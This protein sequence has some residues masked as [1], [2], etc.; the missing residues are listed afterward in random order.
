MSGVRPAEEAAWMPE[1]LRCMT[2]AKSC[3]AVP[4]QVEAGKVRE[5]LYPDERK[6]PWTEGLRQS[7]ELWTA[8]EGMKPG[9]LR[10][11]SCWPD[12]EASLRQPV[13]ALTDCLSL[14]E[15]YSEP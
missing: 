15:Q 7:D 2:L 13:A 9:E 4:L 11:L 5:W 3:P 1:E 14:A 12:T 6:E 8:V 10:S